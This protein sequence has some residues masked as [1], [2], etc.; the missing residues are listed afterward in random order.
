MNAGDVVE[1]NGWLVI[2]DYRP[3]VIPED[4]PEDYE[5]GEKIELSSPEIIFS[6]LDRVLPLGGGRSFLF[7][8]VKVFGEVVVAS[9]LKVKPNFLSVME[10]GGGFLSVSVDDDSMKKYKSSYERFVKG[11]RIV[12]NDWLDFL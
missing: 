11:K 1:L 4:Y 12:S 3:F 6:V 5:S 7:H 10:R 2:I 9:P 8:R